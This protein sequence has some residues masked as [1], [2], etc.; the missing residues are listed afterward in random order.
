MPPRT[1]DDTRFAGVKNANANR[2]IC[3]KQSDG[4]ETILAVE[5][6]GQLTGLAVAIL[7]ANTVGE[8]PRM[9]A[10]Q[11]RLR[12]RRDAKAKGGFV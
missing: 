10:T 7:P 12:G 5:D 11:F 2:R 4:Q 9:T 3:V 6:D 8:Q 1:V